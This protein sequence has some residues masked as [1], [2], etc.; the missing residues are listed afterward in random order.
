MEII[1]IDQ[2]SEEWHLIRGLAL[3]ASDASAIGNHGK[4]LE[5]LVLNKLKDYLAIEK[6]EQYKSPAME[7][8]IEMEQE[9]RTIYEL[10]TGNSVEEVG[11][12]KYTEHS[13]GSPDGLVGKEGGIEIK[14]LTG[15]PY[16]ELW[17][18]NKPESKYLW[19]IQMYMLIT[20][21]SWWDFWAYNPNYKKTFWYKR[22]EKDE[23]KH[24]KLVE[25]IK[26]GT[27]MLLEKYNLLKTE[28]F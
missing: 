1:N 24:K 6:E 14:C 15:K 3:T 9:A 21:R 13:G 16:L 2:R 5:T 4:G 17:F 28:G 10:E 19:Q 23:T 12:I 18:S 25:G 8:G 27:E 20:G 7:R 26:I 11:Y 22:Y